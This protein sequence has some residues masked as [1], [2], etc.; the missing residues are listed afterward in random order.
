MKLDSTIIKKHETGL[1]NLL[2]FFDEK[3][4]Y[5]S[6]PNLLYAP[7]YDDYKHLARVNS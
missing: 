4:F 7:K 5:I 3:K 2:K 6:Y 1:V